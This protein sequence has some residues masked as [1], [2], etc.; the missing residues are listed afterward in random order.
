MKDAP[1]ELDALLASGVFEYANC[2]EITLRDGIGTVLRLTDHDQDVALGGD[3]YAH[4][5]IKGARLRVVRGLEVDEQS[6]T[7][8]PPADYSLRGRPVRQLIRKGLFDR[9][10]IMQRRAFFPDWASPCTG[11]IVWFYGEVTDPSYVGD[12][13][14]FD[15]S[16]LLVL[17]NG[18]VPGP[19]YQ[20]ACRHVFGSDPCG[21]NAPALAVA[22]TVEA[23]STQ[24]AVVCDRMEADH[25]WD[26]G[27]ITMTSGFN[28]GLMRSVKT[29]SPGLLQLY[30]PFPYAPEPGDTFEVMPGCDKTL[31]R[32]T[33]HA[34]A[35]RF[36]GL[37]FVPVPETGT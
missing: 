21:M 26:H 31:V 15:V 34:N 11:W 28:A 8:T 18:S 7:W 32:C 12:T 6:I 20:A 16:S 9:A 1:P 36:G 22:G 24:G 27:R 17:L 10:R 14:T 30:G 19:V 13:I 2:F 3:V 23:G 25:V 29:S 4:A 37:P 33:S 5:M 35:V